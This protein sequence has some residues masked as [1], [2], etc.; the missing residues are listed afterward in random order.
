MTVPFYCS[1]RKNIIVLGV[2]LMLI[3][4]I[5][6]GEAKKEYTDTPFDKEKLPSMSVDSVVEL[7]SDSGLIRYKLITKTWLFF[8][9]A[10]DPYWY[11]PDGL[12]VEQFDTSFQ[13]QA[14]LK[15]DTAWNYTQR[16]VWKLAGN[17]F[18]R[19][20]KD[21]TFESDEL[22]WDE[23]IGKVYSDKYMKITQPGELILHGRDGFESNQQMTQYRVFG[24]YD[25]EITV[26]ENAANKTEM[27][28]VAAPQ[29]NN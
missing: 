18:V 12:Y 20:S 3:A 21:E 1:G 6:C 13:I 29:K 11:F 10:A 14:T 5:G 19:N 8:D 16:K 7:I 25:G 17:V 15:A 28:T 4:F 27:D 2:L 24:P 22:F 23:R 9:N 26:K